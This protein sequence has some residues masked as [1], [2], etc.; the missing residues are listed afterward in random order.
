[1]K[2]LKKY[3]GTFRRQRLLHF[4][5][6]MVWY[7][8]LRKNKE[9]YTRYGIRK[10]V[11]FGVSHKD[12]GSPSG[13]KPWLDTMDAREKIRSNATF[14][15][16]SPAVQHELLAWPDQGY[17]IL[18]GFVKPDLCEMI[19]QE[20]EKAIHDGKVDHDYTNSR[21][22][23]FYEH[24]VSVREVIYSPSLNKL[25]DFILGK[26]TLA[27]QS[28]NFT[29][30]SQQN[31]HSDSIH[32]TTEPLGYLLAIWVALEDIAA[33][34]GPL[35]YY[36]GSHKLPYVMSEHFENDNNFF[37]IGENYY[38]LYEKKI[39]ETLLE[40]KLEKKIFLARK[41]DLLIWHA[42]L[43]HGGEKRINPLSTR[44][45]LVAHYFCEGDIINY[46]EITQRPAIIKS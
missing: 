39:A 28:I 7:S 26:K 9:L 2:I 6:N 42:N 32:M 13:D 3:W 43:L 23:N 1:M 34:S 21:V 35:H 8:K 14:R 22:M 11:V 24:S 15:E 37:S 29:K 44:K 17:L 46:H 20:L 33:D 31:T 36:P 19:N 12:I 25:L 27:F 41:G 5:N 4:L 40:N 30:G 38:E 45:S 16:F 10:S 18:P